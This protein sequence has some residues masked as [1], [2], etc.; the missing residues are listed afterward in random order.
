MCVSVHSKKEARDCYKHKGFAARAGEVSAGGTPAF[1]CVESPQKRQQ[2]SKQPVQLHS[3]GPA[4]APAFPSAQVRCSFCPASFPFSLSFSQFLFSSTGA[5]QDSSKTRFN[6]ISKRKK[7]KKEEC[8]HDSFLS[9]D[10]S[11]QVDNVLKQNKSALTVTSK[12]SVR[13]LQLLKA[14]ECCC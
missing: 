8:K 4:G 7:K 9:P 5:P 3:T 12:S 1:L 10:T 11:G 2:E 14:Q 6:Y 13:G